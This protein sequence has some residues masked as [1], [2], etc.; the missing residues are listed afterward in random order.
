MC[1]R[2][3]II[4]L[5]NVKYYTFIFKLKLIYYFSQK[6]IQVRCKRLRTIS[7]YTETRHTTTE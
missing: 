1:L 4:E 2:E 3:K 7:L 5:T 6:C